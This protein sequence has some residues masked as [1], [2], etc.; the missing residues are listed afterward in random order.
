[1]FAQVTPSSPIFTPSLSTKACSQFYCIPFYL[2][3]ECVANLTFYASTSGENT[4]L[5]EKYNM[6]REFKACTVVPAFLDPSDE[7]T[8]VFEGHL[9]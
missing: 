5:E 8:P 1:L 7:I 2:F 4:K 9:T 6:N 3:S